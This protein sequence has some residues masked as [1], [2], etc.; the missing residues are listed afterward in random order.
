MPIRPENKALYP[1]DWSTVIR[2][3]ILARAGNC[4]ERC[5][6]PNGRTIVR[7]MFA[8]H[9]AYEMG[10]E[11]YDAMNGEILAIGSNYLCDI[12]E[13]REVKIVLTIAHL[14]DMNPAACSWDNLAALCQRCHLIHDQAHH[15]Q[16]RR[17][18][19]R[20]MLACGDLFDGNHSA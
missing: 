19:R 10:E 4:C 5:K 12:T 17:Q 6:V 11:V 3:T 20:S 8:G 9:H 2:P 7:R 13:G 18:T 14:V 15:A 1:K 16:T